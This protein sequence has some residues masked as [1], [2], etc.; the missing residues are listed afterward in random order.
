M[1]WSARYS[2]IS[3]KLEFLNIFPLLILI[4]D[5]LKEQLLLA[6]CYFITF[7]HNLQPHSGKC[8]NFEQ[9][10]WCLLKQVQ[11]ISEK[12]S[13]LEWYGAWKGY[14]CS[15]PEVTNIARSCVDKRLCAA[16]T[17][18]SVHIQR[19]NIRTKHVEVESQLAGCV[20]RGHSTYETTGK[21]SLVALLT[22]PG[23]FRVQI[24]SCNEEGTSVRQGLRVKPLRADFSL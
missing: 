3:T 24:I 4:T 21:A 10:P 22:W 1:D 23:S 15:I 19:A 11:Y 13:H 12:T 14:L 7:K 8:I 16:I 9:W 5:F 2:R 17:W 18:A 6:K 20:T